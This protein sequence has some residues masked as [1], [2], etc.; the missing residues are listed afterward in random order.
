MKRLRLM[1]DLRAY[2]AN[3]LWVA[4]C[5]PEW[6]RFQRALVNVEAAQSRLLHAYLAAN[7]A[8]DFGRR[9]NFAS[10]RSAAEY[11]KAVP[12][13]AY[14]DYAEP[15]AAIGLGQP[16]VLTAEPVRM[17]E[18]SSGSTAASKL[19]PYTATL[20]AEFQRGLAPWIY[21]LYSR[22][23]ELKRGPAYWSITP[24][25]DGPRT[26]AGGIPIGFEADSAYLGALGQHLLEWVLA[27]PSAI[28]QVASTD[29]FRYVT[30]LFLL[31]QPGLRLISVWHPSFLSL[32]MAPL[33]AWWEGLLADIG[34]GTL[35]PPEPLEGELQRLLG[36]RLRPDPPRARQLAA[37]VPDEPAALW[38]EMRLLSC[39][40]DGPA[41]GYADSVS[42]ALF[43]GAR[44]QPKGLLA[45]E[46]FVSLPMEGATGGA[47]SVAVTSHFFEFLPLEGGSRPAEDSPRLAHELEVGQA[48]AVVVTTGGGFYRYAL[49]DIV[50]VTG[51]L[52][53]APCLRFVGKTDLVS[54]RFGEKLNERFVAQA[55]QAMFQRHSLAPVFNLLAPEESADGVRYTLYLE[56]PP[57]Q[58]AQP[59]AMQA[60]LERRLC[61]NFNYAYCRK[62]GQLGEARVVVARPGAAERYLRACQARGQKL[63]GIKPALLQTTAG[64]GPELA[65]EGR[66]A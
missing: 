38:P 47:R 63:G 58:Q 15:I 32:L 62:L 65:G 54:D 19:I 7:A 3:T 33:P 48:Y 21:D 23:P 61:E 59:A 56:L 51:R 24:L 29:A 10:I 36:N 34:A 17:F 9:H 27:A 50:E 37:M 41:A 52:G 57:G 53:Q 13:S 4:S 28:K 60:E 45:T 25:T 66:E 22:D 2:A 30:L 31:R 49:H 39:W 5:R 43:P 8:T 55:S 46:A 44:V 12:L 18:L 20:K 35:T 42:A 11:Q 26:T 16:G 14:D 6:V 1:G 40:A 64:W